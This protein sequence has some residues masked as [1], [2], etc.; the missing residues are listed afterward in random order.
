MPVFIAVVPVIVIVFGIALLSGRCLSRCCADTGRPLEELVQLTAVEPNASAGGAVINFNTLPI[1][2][3]QGFVVA[4]GTFHDMHFQNKKRAPRTGLKGSLVVAA[5]AKQGQ[6]TG[7]Q[8]EHGDKQADRGQHV[9]ALS[10]IDD[11]TGFK[12]DQTG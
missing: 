10:A 3:D 2:H 11:L 8:I 9:I 12:Q 7:E 5:Y 4:L 1:G 6:Q